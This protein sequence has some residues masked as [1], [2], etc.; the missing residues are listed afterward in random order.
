[1]SAG[2]NSSCPS[3]RA[4]WRLLHNFVPWAVAGYVAEQQPDEPKRA[5][6][7]LLTALVL[8]PLASL[9]ES[10]LLWHFVSPHWLVL[11][12]WVIRLPVTGLIARYLRRIAQ[13]RRRNLLRTIFRTR[14]DWLESLIDERTRILD[15]FRALAEECQPEEASRFVAPPLGC[16]PN[17]GAVGD[18][19]RQ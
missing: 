1:M 3:R 6:T 11:A 4:G 2:L 7:G 19:R 16:L 12:V 17:E 14:P 8:F 9:S 10:Y 5:I 15:H 18:V 13:Y